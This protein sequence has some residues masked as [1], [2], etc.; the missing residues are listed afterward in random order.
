MWLSSLTPNY[1]LLLSSSTSTISQRERSLD[2]GASPLSSIR[3]HSTIHLPCGSPPNPRP[4]PSCRPDHGMVSAVSA[5]ADAM[6]A[7]SPTSSNSLP[8][9]WK[10]CHHHLQLP[11]PFSSSQWQ[12]AKEAPPLHGWGGGSTPPL[13]YQRILQS[14]RPPSSWGE[15]LRQLLQPWW[16]KKRNMPPVVTAACWCLFSKKVN[17]MTDLRRKYV[18]ISTAAQLETTFLWHYFS[19]LFHFLVG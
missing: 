6:A 2:T 14:R 12:G 16:T 7:S 1:T 19:F 15:Q 5:K 3:Y 10:N 4:L 11:C 13:W 9:I 8:L 17:F 18:C